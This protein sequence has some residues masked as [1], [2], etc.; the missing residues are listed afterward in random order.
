MCFSIHFSFFSLT[1]SMIMSPVATLFML[2]F[3]S[4]KSYKA[5]AAALEEAEKK[6][7]EGFAFKKDGY[8]SALQM[9]TIF[10]TKGKLE[11]GVL[12]PN[13]HTSQEL[14]QANEK[15]VED[16]ANEHT[17]ILKKLRKPDVAAAMPLF[18][19]AISWHDKCLKWA[20]KSEAPVPDKSDD[21][22][23]ATK[24]KSV[25]QELLSQAHIMKGNCLYEVSQFKAAVDDK[26]WK[27][28]AEKAIDAF[29]SSGSKPEDIRGALANHAKAEE[30]LPLVPVPKEKKKLPA[31][32]GMGL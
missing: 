1:H 17:K 32:K 26:D 27:S 14:A 23:E 31:P 18:E 25:M 29:K 16:A 5:A 12:F 13:P 22:E 8:D 3:K 21:K 19:Q 9:A 11:A 30:L 20:P 10:E 24:E 15:E 6:C 2:Q 4:D 28:W 7:H